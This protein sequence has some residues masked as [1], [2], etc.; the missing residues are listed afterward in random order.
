MRAILTTILASMMIIALPGVAASDPTYEVPGTA[1]VEQATD[2]FAA[3]A[4]SELNTFY[5]A[6]S[7]AQYDAAEDLSANTLPASRVAA[8]AAAAGD[9]GASLVGS[10]VALRG[11]LHTYAEERVENKSAEAWATNDAAVAVG[12]AAILAG[13]T[14]GDAAVRAVCADGLV[15]SVSGG[16]CSNDSIITTAVTSV[17]KIGQ[18]NSE[19]ASGSPERGHILVNA[20]KQFLSNFIPVP[21]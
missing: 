3:G 17:Q 16:A 13:D 2:D 12:E 21:A 20:V 9:F 15:E 18:D 1:P 5:G 7:N 4:S 8:V 11:A 10:G 6:V 14:I 19:E